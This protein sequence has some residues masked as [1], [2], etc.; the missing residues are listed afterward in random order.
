MF[1]GH[2]CQNEPVSLCT[3]IPFSCTI[4][5]MAT[6]LPHPPTCYAMQA[7]STRYPWQPHGHLIARVFKLEE[8]YSLNCQCVQTMC[9]ST[10]SSVSAGPNHGHQP[11]CFHLVSNIRVLGK[12]LLLNL[13]YYYKYFTRISMNDTSA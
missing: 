4:I 3:N 1:V 11:Y 8:L 10:F 12:K 6:R 5:V 9:N 13:S 2:S 7:A